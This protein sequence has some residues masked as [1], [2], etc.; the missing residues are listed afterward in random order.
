MATMIEY[1]KGRHI[2]PGEPIEVYR[3]LNRKPGVW[4]SIRQ[5]G[6][7]VGHARAISLSGCEFVV[8][9]GGRK[10]ALREGRKNVHAFVRGVHIG[11]AN[12]KMYA[13]IR[14]KYTPATGF[15]YLHGEDWAALEHSRYA[16]LSKSGMV[17]G[18][19]NPVACGV[20]GY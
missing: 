12:A 7:V 1:Y 15:T 5:D 10:R 4:Y 2:R 17:V 6:V 3:N 8:Q 11:G 20:V 19:F 14:A 16:Y 9:D 18:P 13:N